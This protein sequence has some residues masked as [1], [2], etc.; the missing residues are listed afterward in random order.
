MNAKTAT[1]LRLIAEVAHAAEAGSTTVALRGGWA[2]DFL[3]G[4]VTRLHEDIDFV[5]WVDDR[6]AVAA[7]LTAA[8][9]T[10][11]SASASDEQRRLLQNFSKDGEDVQVAFV[12]RM[13]SGDLAPPGYPEYTLS[14][15]VL[16]G[17]VVALGGVAC[18][19]GTAEA[20]LDAK[21]KKLFWD[22]GDEY[23]EKD[24][25]DMEHLRAL[26]RG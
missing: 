2:V 7:A 22:E 3:V 23:R 17:P 1:Q 9:F 11:L 6:D 24:I 21:E 5:A 14:P 20:L 4:H 13:A 8:G 12:E 10:S 15:D 18:R 19:V 16:A 25:A 26:I